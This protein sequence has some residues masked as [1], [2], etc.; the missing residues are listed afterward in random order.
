[1]ELLQNIKFLMKKSTIWENTYVCSEKYRFATAL[2]LLSMFSNSYNIVID[3][4]VGALGYGKYI[5]D[6]LNA[7]TNRFL[8]NLTY[9]CADSR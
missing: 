9:S 7:T 6:G 1:M 3:C 4:C 5:V 2:Y 8:T